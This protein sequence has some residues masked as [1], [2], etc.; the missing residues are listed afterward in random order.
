[1]S[2]RNNSQ[3]IFIY[4]NSNVS[5]QTKQTIKF[6]GPKIWNQIPLK[7]RNLKVFIASSVNWCQIWIKTRLCCNFLNWVL[8]QFYEHLLSVTV[9]PCPF[10]AEAHPWLFICFTYILGLAKLEGGIMNGQGCGLG[11]RVR[12]GQ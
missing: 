8:L 9:F 10:L 4:C 2:T 5:K 6:W 11:R 1:M 3:I 12:T 7:I